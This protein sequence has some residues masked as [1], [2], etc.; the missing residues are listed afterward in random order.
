MSL[1]KLPEI[2]A[3]QRPQAFQWDA[4]SEVLAKWSETP[5]AAAGDEDNV[6]TI[7]DVIGEDWWSGAGVTAKRISAALRTIGTKDVVVRINSPGGDMFEGIA[8]YNPL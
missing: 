8:I 7:Y 4:P 3:F 1:R 6:I 2:K 5:R